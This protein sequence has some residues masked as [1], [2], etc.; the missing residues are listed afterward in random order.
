[1]CVC[2]LSQSKILS[3][4]HRVR[5]DWDEEHFCRWC[6][7]RHDVDVLFFRLQLSLGKVHFANFCIRFS[8]P[9]PP[10]P[11]PSLPPRAEDS[12]GGRTI[13][14]RPVGRILCPSR[15]ILWLRS[16]SHSPPLPL[17][18]PIS[19]PLSF[20]S[21]FFPFS[22]N[23]QKRRRRQQQLTEAFLMCVCV[24]ACESASSSTSS[25]LS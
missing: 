20:L 17:T 2:W 18:P 7:P 8:L 25:F 10:P 9:T 24:C 5:G 19:P 22:N 12:N 15:W 16:P 14:V 11:S 6:N 23:P 3:M 1:M 4:S 13:S 21:S